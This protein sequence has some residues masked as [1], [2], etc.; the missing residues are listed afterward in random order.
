[1]SLTCFLFQKSFRPSESQLFICVFLSSF[2]CYFCS[3]QEILQGVAS[4]PFPVGCLCCLPGWGGARHGCTTPAARRRA[5]GP[6]LPPA[7][8]TRLLSTLLTFKPK[9]R[10]CRGLQTGLQPLMTL[11]TQSMFPDGCEQLWTPF[12]SAPATQRIHNTKVL[13]RSIQ[14]FSLWAVFNWARLLTAR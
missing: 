9:A 7:P 2:A 10:F 6:A 3:C 1:M 11:T 4:S 8:S 14:F 12:C 13:L 5:A